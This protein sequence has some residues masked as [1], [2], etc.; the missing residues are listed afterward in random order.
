M[1]ADKPLI[2]ITND[3]GIGCPGITALIE[4]VAPLGEIVVVAPV[5]PR[6]AQSNA[7]TTTVPLRAEIVSSE[8]GVTI[9]KCSGTPTDCVKIAIRKLLPRFP[10]IVLSG[11]NH[12]RN[13]SIS[14][15]YSGTMGA[16][17]EGCVDDIPSI[18][19]SHCSYDKSYDM[20]LSKNI[21]YKVTSHVLTE[22]LPRYTCLNVNIPESEEIKGIRITRQ[23]NGSWEEKFEHR[24]DPIGQDYYWLAGD[25]VE[26]EP[27]A[28]DTDEWAVNNGY[29]SICPV[30]LD[31]TDY[32]YM[33]HLEDWKF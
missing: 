5:G 30:R 7:I 4:A 17:L 3:D 15:I 12:G 33:K 2:L 27:S 6:S 13:T 19:F 16:A 23:A 29:V 8:D 22:G 1:N 9:W 21:V 28:E 32:K 31:M 18:G 20:S 10:D 14:V 25:L 26:H 24:K 11:I